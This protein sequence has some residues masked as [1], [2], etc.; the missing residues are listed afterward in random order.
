[1]IHQV[2]ATFFSNRP[3]LSDGA[4]DAF[5]TMMPSILVPP[6][7]H[8]MEDFVFFSTCAGSIA[9]DGYPTKMWYEAR[10]R[11]VGFLSFLNY[12][13]LITS[14]NFNEQTTNFTATKSHIC[15]SQS[16]KIKHSSRINWRSS[17]YQ[18]S[19]FWIFY[20]KLIIG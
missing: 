3:D 10:D 17:C 20:L 1:M 8:G 16:A 12:Y 2:V 9:R 13:Y 6:V 11:Q 14:V 18:V 7:F 4:I 15:R 19:H 5:E